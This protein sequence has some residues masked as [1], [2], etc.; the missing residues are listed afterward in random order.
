V[1]T[2]KRAKVDREKLYEDM[3]SL[4]RE[5]VLRVMNCRG[6][7]VAGTPVLVASWDDGRGHVSTSDGVGVDVLATEAVAGFCFLLGQGYPAYH[8]LVAMNRELSIQGKLD[9]LLARFAGT[10]E[11]LRCRTEFDKRDGDARRDGSEWGI[12]QDIIGQAIAA[13][14]SMASREEA[15]WRPTET[16][17]EDYYAL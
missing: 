17:P 16:V 2:P 13:V 12:S 11:S 3:E 14:A 4:M 15:D 9:N 6:G 8:V 5:L 10:P 7:M 1:E